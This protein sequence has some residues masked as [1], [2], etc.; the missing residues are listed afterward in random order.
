MKSVLQ[1][2][3]LC[4]LVLGLFSQCQQNES[5]LPEFKYESLGLEVYEETHIKGENEFAGQWM[6]YEVALTDKERYLLEVKLEGKNLKMLVG[7]A[8]MYLEQLAKDVILTQVEKAALSDFADK[9]SWLLAENNKAQA[10]SFTFTAA[11]NTLYRVAD[12]WSSAPR[13]M[14]YKNRVATINL[15]KG[16]GD[17]GVQCIRKNQQYTLSYTNASGA[18]TTVNRTAGYNGGGSYKCMGRCGGSCGRWWIPSSWTLDC[19]EH[20][21]C[22]LQLNASG[23]PSDSNCGDEWWEAADDWSFGVATGCFG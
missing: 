8:P 10:G 2:L 5:Q 12:L 14:V 20:D 1:K 11:E 21:E 23:G 3:I 17:D 13:N 15:D 7:Y 6:R 22:S 4:S 9:F 16:T 18:V 19:F